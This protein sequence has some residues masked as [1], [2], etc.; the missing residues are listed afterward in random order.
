MLL[1]PASDPPPWSG[2]PVRLGILAS[3]SGSNFAA[4]ADAAAA[5]GAPYRIAGL[6]YNNP[7]AYVATRASERGI[8]ARLVDH[9]G[10]GGREEFDA[11]VVEA[12]RAM[13][14]EWVAMAG[15]MR[16]CTPVLLDAFADRVLNLHPSLLPSFRGL[17]AVEQA[18]AAGVTISGCTVHLVR[19]AV[20]DG[21]IIAQAAVPVLAG[22]DADALHQRIHAAEHALYPRAIA[23][24]ISQARAGA[25]GEGAAR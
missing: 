25:E 4:I 6:V 8:P 22:D 11:A 24:A 21:P 13:E 20:D 19:P 18:L 12:L 2:P 1:S 10:F 5:G 3:G 9:R 17:R 23:L 15:W 7:G 16:I 14:V